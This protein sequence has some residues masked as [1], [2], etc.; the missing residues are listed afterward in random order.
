MPTKKKSVKKSK[1]FVMTI[2]FQKYMREESTGETEVVTYTGENES[3]VL[4]QIL[5]N[6]L[7][8]VDNEEESVPSARELW[9]LIEYQNGDG[10][11]YISAFL[12]GEAKVYSGPRGR[13]KR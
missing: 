13:K 3:E 2:V 4:L 5:E 9:E 8:C 11:D 7:Y 1:P 10:A 6:H 12:I